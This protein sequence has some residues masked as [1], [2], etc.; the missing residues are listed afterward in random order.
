MM[1][2]LLVMAA[3]KQLLADKD[4]AAAHT[5]AKKTKKQKQKAKKQHQRERQQPADQQPQQ[6]SPAEL[7][8]PGRKPV[9]PHGEMPLSALPSDNGPALPN[10][11]AHQRQFSAGNGSV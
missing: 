5:A 1:C 11:P 2:S 4:E 8:V 3:G 9:L 7:Q 10:G 6:T